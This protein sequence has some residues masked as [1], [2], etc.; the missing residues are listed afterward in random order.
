MA[1]CN[2]DVVGFGRERGKI[3]SSSR[4]GGNE[5][6]IWRDRW[7]FADLVRSAG[8][9]WKFWG[10]I[11]EIWSSERRGP[12]ARREG[13]DNFFRALTARTEI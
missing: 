8:E 12:E 5:K 6:E 10:K 13:E 9:S 1:I 4:T 2:R 11:G 7:G 3:S